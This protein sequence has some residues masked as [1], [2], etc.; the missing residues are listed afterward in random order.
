MTQK[1]NQ[2]VPEVLQVA[3]SLKLGGG[4]G[5]FLGYKFYEQLFDVKF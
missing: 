4:G 1:I 2:T 3:R 5:L